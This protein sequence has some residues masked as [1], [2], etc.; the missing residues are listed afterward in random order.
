MP[1]IRMKPPPNFVR[2]LRLE[3]SGPVDPH[4]LGPLMI[5]RIS[6][7]DDVAA[8]ELDGGVNNP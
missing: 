4:V 5:I 1:S 3:R 8:C 7:L 6:D 2:R